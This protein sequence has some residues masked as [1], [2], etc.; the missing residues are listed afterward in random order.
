MARLLKV[1]AVCVL[2]LACALAVLAGETPSAKATRKKLQQK[3]SVE[4]KEQATKAVFDVEIKGEMDPPVAFKIDNA[5]GLSNNTKLSY[6]AKEKTVEAILNELA[7]K[8]DFGWFVKSDPKDRNDGFVI[9][10]RNKDKERGYEAGKELKKS[11]E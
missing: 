1:V 5:S 7:D 4:F 8:F 9:I 3:I 2:G 10:R 11:T 6:K